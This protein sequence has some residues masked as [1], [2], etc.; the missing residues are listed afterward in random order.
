LRRVARLVGAE[1]RFEEIAR[2]CPV[3]DQAYTCESITTS[4]VEYTPV[5][6]K[7][8]L[9]GVVV[10]N[11]DLAEAKALPAPSSF[12][13]VIVSREVKVAALEAALPVKEIEEVEP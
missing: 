2:V 5:K 8:T 9:A 10:L 12:L 13:P 3:C 4:V 6:L 11:A 1:R 7:R